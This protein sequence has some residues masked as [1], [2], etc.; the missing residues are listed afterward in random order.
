MDR[1]SS[2]KRDSIRQV[3]RGVDRQQLG[4]QFDMKRWPLRSISRA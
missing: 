2:S 1:R 4:S 3:V